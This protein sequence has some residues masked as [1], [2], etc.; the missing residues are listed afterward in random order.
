[1]RQNWFDQTSM[2]S[3]STSIQSV[4]DR[5]WSNIKIA[6][7]VPSN[8]APKFLNRMANELFQFGLHFCCLR[9]VW[10]IYGWSRHWW[11]YDFMCNSRCLA[12]QKYWLF[13][14]IS[15]SSF[16]MWMPQCEHMTISST[17]SIESFG[18]FRLV[19]WSL[20]N[21]KIRIAMMIRNKIF[22][23]QV[24]HFKILTVSDLLDYSL[25]YNNLRYR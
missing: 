8:H 16:G 9:G 14:L 19:F 24:I 11:D 4:S 6:S 15:A 25:K 20:I 1:M 10:G 18:L 2:K 12:E 23:I 21:Q 5:Y 13:S 17:D 3:K 7:A 22:P